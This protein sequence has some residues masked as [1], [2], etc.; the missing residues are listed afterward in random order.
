MLDTFL[1]NV[2][3]IGEKQWYKACTEFHEG[4]WEAKTQEACKILLR[5][6]IVHI[7]Q[8][9][10]Y[11]PKRKEERSKHVR[12]TVIQIQIHSFYVKATIFADRLGNKPGNLR[13]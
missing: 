12:C 2:L 13:S 7:E 3:G 4:I 10:T 11:F 9:F 5:L 1:D 8:W 6:I